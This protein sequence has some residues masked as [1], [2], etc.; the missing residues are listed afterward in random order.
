MPAIAKELAIINQRGTGVKCFYVAVG[1][2]E[3]NVA[4]LVDG[5]ASCL[6]P[7]TVPR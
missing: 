3:S 1:Q 7:V 2:K 5:V 4:A 6:E